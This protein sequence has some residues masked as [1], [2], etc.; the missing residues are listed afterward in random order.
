MLGVLS[1]A[2]LLCGLGM[3]GLCTAPTWGIGRASAALTDHWVANVLGAILLPS[4]A[5]VG[6][7]VAPL[8]LAA[9]SMPH[10]RLP[11]MCIWEASMWKFHVP[12]M[13]TCVMGPIFGAFATFPFPAIQII[14]AMSL[15]VAWA[16][17]CL[18]MAFTWA[19]TIKRQLHEASLLRT[20][21]GV[22]LVLCGVPI[23][24]AASVLGL[25]AS[26]FAAVRGMELW[27]TAGLF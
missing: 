8:P 16:A 15:L 21:A 3:Y 7:W 20:R 27:G 5:V 13:A 2:V 12:W 22:W 23:F 11:M 19:V 26:I 4:I 18:I 14:G 1:S 25:L 17:I 24:F 6:A 9:I 10:N